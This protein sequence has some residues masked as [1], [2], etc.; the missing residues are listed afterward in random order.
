MLYVWMEAGRNSTPTF[1]CQ[2]TAASVHGALPPSSIR[3]HNITASE[4]D[5]Q[6]V[7]MRL[8]S[9]CALVNGTASS[10]TPGSPETEA[11]M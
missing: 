3:V 8:Q 2:S 1:T 5:F 10:T 7:R 4:I 11:L 6:H 9:R